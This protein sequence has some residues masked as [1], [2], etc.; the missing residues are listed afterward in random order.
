MEREK[1]EN[2]QM[3]RD[4]ASLAMKFYSA[5]W[6][7]KSPEVT[8]VAMTDSLYMSRSSWSAF[9]VTRFVCVTYLKTYTIEGVFYAYNL[10]R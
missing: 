9:T 6:I 1:R 3:Q 7:A 5:Q 2:E 10:K 8:S 4:M